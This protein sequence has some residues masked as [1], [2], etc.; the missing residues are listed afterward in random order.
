[1]IIP[2]MTYGSEICISDFKLKFET[3]DKSPFEKTHN[4]IL[5]NLLWVHGR[6]SNMAVRCEFGGFSSG[7]KMLQTHVQLFSKI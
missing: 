1:M 7:I 4:M 5:I 2:I 3:L 6:S